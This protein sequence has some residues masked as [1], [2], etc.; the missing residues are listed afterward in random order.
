MQGPH[1]RS[2]DSAAG[3]IH[4]AVSGGRC[5]FLAGFG[6]PSEGED[7]QEGL[8]Q[9]LRGFDAGIHDLSDH[10]P[11]GN[12]LH[13]TDGLLDPDCNV[14][15]IYD[16]R[17]RAGDQGADN[18]EESG[19]SSDQLHWHHLSDSQPRSCAGRSYGKHAVRNI[20]DRAQQS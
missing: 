2:S 10:F 6:L 4:A 1:E 9:D 5:A 13:H 3:D 14:T 11:G 7:R 15:D 18:H 20:H 12:P 19:R 8:H 16:D 17:C